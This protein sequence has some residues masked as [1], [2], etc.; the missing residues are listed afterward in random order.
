MSCPSMRA[1]R[2]QVDNVHLAEQVTEGLK[3]MEVPPCV[4]GCVVNCREE[5]AT[6]DWGWASGKRA[7][8][9]SSSGCEVIKTVPEAPDSGNPDRGEAMRLA[10]SM[11]EPMAQPG[12]SNL[13]SATRGCARS[14]CYYALARGRRR[15]LTPGCP[16]GR[17]PGRQCFI[18]PGSSRRR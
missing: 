4:M 13:T 10:D 7:R 12:I 6:W 5:P 8:A 1:K 15:T 16:A 14:V 3:G 9:R 17:Q 2:A 18:S 11:E